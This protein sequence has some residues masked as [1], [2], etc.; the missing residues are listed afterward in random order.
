MAVHGR[1]LA[2][3]VRGGR[4]SQLR[5]TDCAPDR[6]F[7]AGGP[8]PWRPRITARLSSRAAVPCGQRPSGGH[9]PDGRGSQPQR[10]RDNPGEAGEGGGH[11]PGTAE[12]RNTPTIATAHA[13]AASSGHLPGWPRIA[14][15][16]GPPSPTAALCWRPP[17]AAAEDRN[18]LF[19]EMA[20]LML[21]AL[22]AAVRG[23]R[24]SQRLAELPVR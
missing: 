6:G 8:R 5:S 13:L 24:G 4:G 14:T 15:T 11:P 9:S 16:I 7:G 3:A 17:S 23:G 19:G 22:A 1:V 10:R 20:G 12:D 2:A 21:Y 18:L